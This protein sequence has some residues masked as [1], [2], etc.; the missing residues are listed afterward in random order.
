MRRAQSTGQ[1]PIIVG[2][3]GDS[4]AGKT[5]LTTGLVHLLGPERVIHICTDD[6]HKYDRIERSQHNITALHP[7]CNYLDIIEQHLERMYYGQPIL[8]PVYDHSTGSLVRPRY[9]QPREFVIVEGLL[10]FHS[11]VMRQFYDIKVFLDPPE[12]L[13]KIWKVKRDTAKRGYNVEQVLAEL[14]KREPDS[15][16]FIRPQREFADVIVRFQPPAEVEPEQ[17]NGHLNVRLV[18]R[19]TIPHPDLNYLLEDAPNS[20]FN[21]RLELGRDCGRPVDILEIDGNVAPEHVTRLENQIWQHLPDLRPLRADEFGTY[22]DRTDTRHSD[23][24]ALTQLL[25]TYH[26]L[27]ARGGAQK[28]LPAVSQHP[29]GV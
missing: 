9:I 11:A 17:A 2:I 29:A 16:D 24:L 8:K 22:V 27:R 1:R 18:L 13:R 15:R 28:S 23:P 4:A 14:E 12:A 26:M 25:L 7:D 3:V 6:Y 21:V 5:T 10:G 19:P 20:N